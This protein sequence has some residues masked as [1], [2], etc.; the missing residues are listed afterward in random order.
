MGHYNKGANRYDYLT[1]RGRVFPCSWRSGRRQ[2]LD[3]SGEPRY[4]AG[5]FVPMD[6]PSGC[7][8]VEEGGSRSELFCGLFSVL[9]VNSRKDFLDLCLDGGCYNP[10]SKPPPLVFTRSLQG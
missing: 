1:E 4:L 7:P 9:A 8:L 6:G 10:V 2:F 5:C 3:F